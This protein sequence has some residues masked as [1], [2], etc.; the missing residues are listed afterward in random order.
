[1]GMDPPENITAV[2]EK[3]SNLLKQVGKRELKRL[4]DHF[5]FYRGAQIFIL[6]HDIVSFI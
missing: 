5:Y 4:W 6:G 2:L 3:G 1:M